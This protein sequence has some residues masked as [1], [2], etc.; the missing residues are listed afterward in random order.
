[1]GTTLA[2]CT[3]RT[4]NTAA[5]RWWRNWFPPIVRLLALT[6]RRLVAFGV[7]GGLVGM[8]AFAAAEN[9]N[10]Q[11]CTSGATPCFQ[12]L[13]P[14]GSEAVS[15]NGSVVV[16]NITSGGTEAATWINGTITPLG[17][18]P[19]CSSPCSSSATAVSPD[20]SV[21]AGYA[22]TSTGAIEAVTWANGTITALGYLPND[23]FSE[24]FGVSANGVVVGG[25]S[26]GAFMWTNG[27]MNSLPY[28]LISCW[29]NACESTAVAV[30][31]NGSII[32]G[33]GGVLEGKYSLVGTEAVEWVNGSITG[34][35]WLTC[36]DRSQSCNSVARAVSS[37]GSVIVGQ[38]TRFQMPPTAVKWVN[39]GISDLGFLPDCANNSCPNG[40][41]ATGVNADGSVIVGNA[42]DGSG[43]G[44]AF[45]WTAAT[46]MQSLQAELAC[47]GLNTIGWTLTTA[48]VSSDGLTFTGK[49][50]TPGGAEEYWIAR[51]PAPSCV[52][53]LPTVTA[54]APSH[55]PLA[56][57][58][59]VTIAGANFFTAVTAV[60][61]GS[62]PAA[63]FS[64]NSATS[65]TATSPPAQHVGTVHVT[66]TTAGVGTSATSA[67]DQFT[68]TQ[69]SH[70]F[71]GDNK[72]DVLWRDTAGDVGMWLMNGTQL[73]SPGTIFTNLP[74]NWSIVGQRDF[75]NDGKT[76]VLVTDTA[77]DVGIW[78]MNGAAIA[79]SIVLGNM[80]TSWSVAGTGDFNGNGFGDILWRS[81]GG[82]VGIWLDPASQI[83]AV[84]LGNV[85]TNWWI[86][87]VGDFNGD[88]YSDILWRDT[89]GDVA[90]W[91]MNG[92]QI[93]QEVSLG[94]VLTKWSI[95]GT[96]DFNGDG[97]ADILW[98]DTD[99]DLGMWL[100]NG[101]QV[102]QIAL[103]PTVGTQWSVVQTG[104]YNGDG[105]SDIL[106]M[107]NTG[108]VGLW[109]MNGTQSSSVTMLP[110]PG[111][112]WQ[113]QG[114]NAD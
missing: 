21:V 23:D 48:V 80:P 32:V 33:Y 65:I 27:T 70:D 15:A 113:A 14:F 7:L 59:T 104:D 60:N 47:A 4:G 41:Y 76:D 64:V 100:M 110:N 67:A 71:N 57:G 44:V 96:G 93:L 22:S 54:V 56:G 69:A 26:Y 81:A 50:F 25:G 29:P 98:R 61:F 92:S 87:G 13:A 75:N 79:Q 102:G 42:V 11:S 103:L 74:A 109:L 38:S 1:M 28:P 94:N 3:A 37:D 106:W 9:A 62:I 85:P 46:G 90:I 77:G 43:T 89:A 78:F 30:S 97:M 51:M 6:A 91:L 58:T 86:A 111:T 53:A 101:A 68:Y 88:G 66:V 2:A 8:A 49:G 10:A 24:A 45:V 35:G 63:S 5:V 84:N 20:G 112:N 107:D 108:D 55:G 72:S 99:G 12:G 82:D 114:T 95:V 39:G 40:S 31:E 19:G 17:F 105:M 34:L 83:Q 18:L 73:L 52:P 36:D 16:G